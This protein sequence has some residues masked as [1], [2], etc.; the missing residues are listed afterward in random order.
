MNV[1]GRAEESSPSALF[2]FPLCQRG[3]QEDWP[4]GWSGGGHSP[5]YGWCQDAR[6]QQNGLFNNCWLDKNCHCWGTASG[7][8]GSL[9]VCRTCV[10]HPVKRII[11]VDTAFDC[12]LGLTQPLPRQICL[13]CA[14]HGPSEKG[15]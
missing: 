12:T 9:Q 13:V 1:R 8:I 4:G 6:C 10:S 14:C 5:P 3:I 15:L 2:L 7:Y 11:A